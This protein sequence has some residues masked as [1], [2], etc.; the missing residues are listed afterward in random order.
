MKKLGIELFLKSFN[1][2]AAKTV[3]KNRFF[4][5]SIKKAKDLKQPQTKKDD[6]TVDSELTKIP[7]DPKPQQKINLKNPNI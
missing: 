3:N 1:L 2:G 5:A 7:T 4:F 6:I